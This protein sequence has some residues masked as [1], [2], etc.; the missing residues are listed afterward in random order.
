MVTFRVM[1]CKQPK[2]PL[3]LLLSFTIPQ[4]FSQDSTPTQ[5]TTSGSSTATSITTG[6][7]DTTGST[8]EII[9]PENSIPNPLESID[10]K[11]DRILSEYPIFDGH[12]DLPYRLRACLENRVND[13]RFNFL[14]DLSQNMSQWAIDCVSQGKI[15]NTDVLDTDY[16]R[17]VKGK[18]GAQFWSVYTSCNSQYRDSTRQTIE[19]IDVVKRLAKKYDEYLVFCTTADC[20]EN[21]W[22]NGKI[23]SLAG[24]EGGHTIDSSLGSL[25]MFKEIGA[26][27]LGLTHFCNTPWADYSHQAV[28]N[29]LATSGIETNPWATGTDEGQYIGGL[30]KFGKRVIRESNRIGI[31]VDLA[32]VSTETMLDAL[33][34]AR[35]PVMF[36]HSNARGVF[37]HPRNVD[38]EVLLKLKEN[39]GILKINFYADYLSEATFANSSLQTAIAHFNYVKNLIGPE[40]IGMGSDFDGLPFTVNGL[41]DAATFPVLFKELYQN[42]GW[43]ELEL[44]MISSKNMLRVLREVEHVA[45]NLQQTNP[46]GW[47][48][49]WVSQEEIGVVNSLR[50]EDFV[51]GCRSDF[52]WLPRRDEDNYESSVE[53]G[54]NEEIFV[55]KSVSFNNESLVFDAGNFLPEK[56]RALASGKL[57]YFD[58]TEKVEIFE[59]D[60][61]SISEAGINV[62]VFETSASCESN[63]KDSVRIGMEQIDLVRRMTDLY[64]DYIYLVK[65]SVQV[66]FTKKLGVL[67]GVKGGHVIGS[68][69]DVLRAFHEMGM[70]KFGLFDGNCGDGLVA[71]Q[72]FLDNVVLEANRLGI[73]LDVS[74]GSLADIMNVI[75]ISQAPV[76]MKWSETL[77]S[78]VTQS[79]KRKSGVFFL[80]G[81]L[82]TVISQ[83]I[84]IKSTLGSEFIALNSGLDAV[85]N[86]TTI[87]SDD[88]ALI[89]ENL[90]NNGFTD[91]E[92]LGVQGGNLLNFLKR[93]ENIAKSDTFLSKFPDESWIP[94]ANFDTD[95]HFMCW[96]DAERVQTDDQNGEN[97]DNSGNSG[98]KLTVG[99]ALILSVFSL[100]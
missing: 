49:A 93:V 41:E 82:E 76:S 95:E 96:S 16:P 1:L 80:N 97:T 70:R 20:I 10:Q 13:G 14:Q 11:I 99:V 8:P 94:K 42:H 85:G 64:S 5:E 100:K 9:S 51:K 38:D 37:N 72:Q 89:S 40:Y 53:D 92:I 65:N 63:Y 15:D 39:K 34:I 43:N 75:S 83:A 48:E 79:M 68:S 30:S 29:P 47:D 26:M 88:Y 59:S 71:W 3:L 4:I 86:A 21:A 98:V 57:K 77:D 25:R 46:S 67:I 35:A 2:L 23:A 7:F 66:D 31:L 61:V 27:Y 56:I 73:W 24:I 28:F 12:N 54:L 90:K 44:K 36:S 52:L 17:L 60:F 32:H 69:L 78:N 84:Y 74:D 19:Q 6:P 18:V 22:K 33:E 91:G 62:Q 45:A 50:E 58:L 81:D 55:V 87:S